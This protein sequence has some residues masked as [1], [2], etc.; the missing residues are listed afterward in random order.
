MSDVIQIAL[1]IIRDGKQQNLQCSR[2][3]IIWCRRCKIIPAMQEVQDHTCNA[4]G[5][6][7]GKRRLTAALLRSFADMISPVDKLAQAGCLLYSS[8]SATPNAYASPSCANMRTDD[9][10]VF[11]FHV[12]YLGGP[13]EVQQ[14][15]FHSCRFTRSQ[16]GSY[17][18]NS[19]S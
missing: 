19:T 2:C 13:T 10:F 18:Q 12:Q 15:E 3:N 17:R 9:G 16:Y 6:S 1:K 14:T 11:A 8:Y 7:A 5:A 4:G